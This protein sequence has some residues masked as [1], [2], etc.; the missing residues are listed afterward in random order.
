MSR[1][2]V[3]WFQSSRQGTLWPWRV[4]H[5]ALW[6]LLNSSSGNLYNEKSNS[7]NVRIP[8]V[9]KKLLAKNMGFR[10][11]TL[12]AQAVNAMK[13]TKLQLNQLLIQLTQMS[14]QKHAQVLKPNQQRKNQYHTLFFKT[15]RKKMKSSNSFHA[16]V[17]VNICRD[18]ALVIYSS[19]DLDRILSTSE[20]GL[21]TNT[22]TTET[23]LISLW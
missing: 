14:L 9:R 23:R 4:S 2:R 5:C 21:I 16:L 6:S 3:I 11:E 13:Q 15:Q 22:Q 12:S 17:V 10:K 8:W 20:L 19:I 7:Q 18:N 1:F